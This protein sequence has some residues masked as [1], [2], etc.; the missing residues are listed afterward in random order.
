M[1]KNLQYAVLFMM[2]ICMVSSCKKTKTVDDYRSEYLSVPEMKLSQADSSEVRALVDNYL[3]C[4]RNNQFSDAVDMLYYMNGVNDIVPMPKDLKDNQL[5]MLQRFRGI[6]Y[7]L[8][9]ITYSKD[10][11]NIASYVV[12][13]FDK[14]KN[15]PRP[16]T[17]RFFI[18]PVRVD[19]K[20]Y[21]T[22][23]DTMS[24]RTGTHGTL[25]KN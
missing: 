5:K 9:K 6:R 22:M 7:D 23:A 13:L 20:W 16:N 10:Y 15:D 17:A 4:L 11:D 2:L 3:L 25:I 8:E 14:Q 21:L 24:D 1:K 12:T 18:K 19:G